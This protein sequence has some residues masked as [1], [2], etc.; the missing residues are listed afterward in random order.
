LDELF[1]LRLRGY[2]TEL[3]QLHIGDRGVPVAF[4]R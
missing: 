1:Q 2:V 4:P 3:A